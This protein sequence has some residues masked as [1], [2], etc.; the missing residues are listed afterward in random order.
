MS[1][2]VGMLEER[3]RWLSSLLSLFN[4]GRLRMG[5]GHQV[6]IEPKF[7][8]ISLKLITQITMLL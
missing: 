6:R 5:N 8:I 4:R 7:R 2:L 3:F 1:C